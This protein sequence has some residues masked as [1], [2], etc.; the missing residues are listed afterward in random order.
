V[1]LD[2]SELSYGELD[3]R[4]NRLAHYLVERGVGPDV[5]V[6]VHMDRSLELVVAMLAVMK[7]GGAYLPL[8]PNYPADRN[9]FMLADTKARV[10][11]SDRPFSVPFDGVR[12]DTRV[13]AAQI[14]NGSSA[15]L[16]RDV[17]AAN[18][19]YI[20]Y[21]SG[22]TGTPKGVMVPHDRVVRLM[23]ATEKW[24]RFDEKDVWTFFHSYAFDFSVWEIWG[25][26]IYGGSVVVVPDA[27]RR[28]PDDLLALLAREKVTVLNQIPS[29]FRHLIASATRGPIV[30]L[31]LRYVIFGGEALELRSLVPWFERYPAP[32]LVNMYGIT[33]TTVHVTYRRIDPAE[34]AE[35]KGSPIGVPI[36]DLEMYVLDS[37]LRPVIEGEGEIY[38]GGK[39]LARGYHAR[40]GLTAE[41]FVP[42]P[43]SG[44]PGD[45]LY[46]TGDLARRVVDGFE[47]LGRNDAQ[48]KIRG[49]RIETGEISSI[50]A[51]HPA[52]REAAVVVKDID[53][54][55]RRLVAY[56]VFKS[57]ASTDDVTTF[58]A[59]RLPE[60]MV[61]AMFVPIEALPITPSGKLDL[62]AL[63]APDWSTR[64]ADNGTLPRTPDEEVLAKLWKEVLRVRKVGIQDDFFELGGHSLLAV[65]LVA[66]IRIALSVEV[67]IG[68]LFALPTIEQLAAE[69]VR[70]R[71]QTTAPQA[72]PRVARDGV[73]LAA[74]AQERVWFLE[75]MMRANSARPFNTA[76][77]VEIRGALDIRLLAQSLSKL[78]ER[79]EILRTNFML[80]GKQLV[81][82][83]NAPEPI[84]LVPDSQGPLVGP[85]RERRLDEIAT[86]LTRAP[87][88]LAK[89]R[90]L[91][92]RLVTFG[93]NDQVLLL[94]MH[95][96]IYD[97][98]AVRVMLD[99]LASLYRGANLP[100]VPL[101]YADIAAWQRTAL[102]S[103]ETKRQ[104]AYWQTQ[105]AGASLVAIPP[106]VEILTPR[107][108]GEFIPVALGAA[109]TAIV[110]DLARAEGA[111]PFMIVIAALV[112]MIAKRTGATDIVVGTVATTR[113]HAELE[114]S[115]GLLLNVLALRVDANGDPSFRV[116]VSRVRA[117]V[118]Q[119]FA[120]DDVPYETIVASLPH[121]AARKGFFQ[122]SV[123]VETV[124]PALSAPAG[125]TWTLSL[126]NTGAVNGDFPLE[127]VD[128]GVTLSGSLGFRTEAFSR[129]RAESLA[130]DF[131]A[132][133]ATGATSPDLPSSQILADDT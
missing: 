1:V 35:P 113:D 59:T 10:V 74:N 3:A 128:D 99:E 39:G 118:G 108:A 46:K 44:R 43:F 60:Y 36:P 130:R 102:S 7:A 93:P 131:I 81:Q 101:Q 5:I 6:G 95:H 77:A 31:A 63:P 55:D 88:D 23:T 17:D 37:S 79:H 119:A 126:R 117:V 122:F 125:Q 73:L 64:V 78:V 18:L 12:I 57:T 24:F 132:A 127:L 129:A 98:M 86:E 22:S 11:I 123:S 8:D 29:A 107:D 41:R 13:D 83:I 89:D 72:I 68:Q 33:E 61:P 65:K 62:A 53:D 9:A 52:V 90:L 45:R 51:R 19:A 100:P 2:N 4:A 28:S 48:V 27:V 87:F 103:E 124:P 106:D 85:Q 116:L 32:K 115:L 25:A 109:E 21:T 66:K 110:R 71:A 67:T 76:F 121:K 96:I 105:L 20:I 16:P 42:D 34:C 82:L 120:H 92:V 58:L 75:R 112:A 104:L 56:V 26:L 114:R 133:L 14:A 111:S 97:G 54:G 80:A 50:L 47:Y 70:M 84:E 15:V 49:H 40:P 94:V 69:I 91:R 30:P 38:V